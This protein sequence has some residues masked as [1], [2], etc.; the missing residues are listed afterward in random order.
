MRNSIVPETWTTRGGVTLTMR[1]AE[2]DDGPKLQALFDQLTPEDLRFRFLTSVAH[3][4]ADRI[5]QMLAPSGG[6]CATALGID[7]N[8]EVVAAAMIAAD[9]KGEEAEVAISVRSD[10]KQR[11][12]GW[13]MLDFV[14]RHARRQG[15]RAL[16]SIESRDNRA[17]IDLEREAG[18]SFEACEGDAS[19]VVARIPL[20]T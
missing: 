16:Y 19:D 15:F 8:G 13:T 6:S 2:P 17:A 11:G 20:S 18:F 1:L 9:D 12:V 4:G 14:R 10:M 7:A 3:V 5:G